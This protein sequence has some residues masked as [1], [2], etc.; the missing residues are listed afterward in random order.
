MRHFPELAYDRQRRSMYVPSLNAITP[1][2]QVFCDEYLTDLNATQAAIRAHY[3]PARAAHA[4]GVL[5]KH[6]PIRDYIARA[7][8]ARSK[9][10]GINADRVLQRLGAI[11]MGDPRAIF[12]EN[13]GLKKPSDMNPED[14]L[15][16]AGVKTRRAVTLG[17]DG[18][19]VPEEITEIKIV[20]NLAA[21]SL[22]MRHLGMM[23]DKLD[24]NVTHSL[25][26]RLANAYTRLN[27]HR[28]GQVIDGEVLA[29]DMQASLQQLEV[30][31]RELQTQITHDVQA[32]P[33]S[34][35]DW[36]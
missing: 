17:D 20:D 18:K 3:P 5:M 7:M 26:E 2:Q 6:P 14:A 13:G 19:M 36:W 24:I 1:Q 11:V 16:L 9:R 12:N 15:M 31:S 27:K 32:E 28:G 22:A 34:N 21:L 33:A 25:A 10:T 29:E 23:N 4:A 35:E 30:E 8:A